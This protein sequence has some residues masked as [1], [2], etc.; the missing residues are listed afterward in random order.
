MVRD[1]ISVMFLGT[2]SGHCAPRGPRKRPP[3]NYFHAILGIAIIGLSLWQVRTGFR[4]E[5]PSVTGRDDVP[6]GVNI[7]WY[8]WVVLLPV[9][10]ALGMAF[11]PKQYRQERKARE[12]QGASSPSSLGYESDSLVQ[13]AIATSYSS[14]S[15]HSK[16]FLDTLLRRDGR[17]MWPVYVVDTVHAIDLDVL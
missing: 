13:Q 17:S 16:R 5:W 8:I 10:Y 3:Q 6:N 7:V 15:K 12:S 14:P 9:A 1:Q 11:L 4:D 2:A